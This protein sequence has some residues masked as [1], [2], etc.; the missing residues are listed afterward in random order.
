MDSNNWR[1]QRREQREKWLEERHRFRDDIRNRYGRSSGRSRVWIGLLLLII[2][3]VALLKVALFPIPEWVYDWPMILIALGLFLGIGHGFRG[4]VWFV[5]ML[6]GGAFLVRNNFPDLIMYKYIWPAALI[7]LGLFFILKPRRN[8]S[9]YTDEGSG[10]AD[11]DTVATTTALKEDVI[12]STSIFGGI[13]KNVISKNF[14]GGDITNIMGGSEIDLSQADINGVA[15]IDLTQV[16]GGTKLIVPSN[17][18]VKT[19]MAAIFGGVED[20]RSAQHAALDPNKILIL[21]GTSIF[22]GIEI[23]SY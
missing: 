23:R 20:K 14:K 21:D 4:G 12:D 17:W 1:E 18:Q 2:G 3:A 11:A 7:I 15:T 22:G 19:Q 16:F 5:L 6:V 9:D 8:W 13:K 10:Q